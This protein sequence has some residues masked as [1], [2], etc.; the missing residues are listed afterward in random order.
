MFIWWISIYFESD[1]IG[2][3]EEQLYKHLVDV[4]VENEWDLQKH[5]CKQLDLQKILKLA[6]DF[7]SIC[8]ILKEL[9]FQLQKKLRN[10]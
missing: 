10:S 8:V 7:R 4:L 6:G 5:K 3:V 9:D 1:I 2:A